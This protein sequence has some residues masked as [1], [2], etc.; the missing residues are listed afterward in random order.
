MDSVTLSALSMPS[1][2]PGPVPEPFSAGAQVSPCPSTSSPWPGKPLTPSDASLIATRSPTV[3]SAPQPWIVPWQAPST[4]VSPTVSGLPS[5]QA[6]V[7]RMWE[8]P[9]SSQHPSVVQGLPSSQSALVRQIA[10]TS[11]YSPPRPVNSAPND[12]ASKMPSPFT[13]TSG[14]TTFCSTVRTKP[15]V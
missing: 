14:V 3:T 4:H 13:S 8:H 15:F 11:W 10:R 1:E 12:T 9:L 7:V 2:Q 5:S 6:A